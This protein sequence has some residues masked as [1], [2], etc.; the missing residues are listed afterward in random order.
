ME[1]FL[2]IVLLCLTAL[3]FWIRRS[4]PGEFGG[5]LASLRA[6]WEGEED[7]VEKQLF[8]RLAFEAACAAKDK[9]G[10]MRY[11]NAN[12]LIV[13]DY[14]RAYLRDKYPDLRVVDR[15]KH[16]TYAVELALIPT[17]FAVTTARFARDPEV[18]GARSHGYA[19]R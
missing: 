5:T 6:A 1:I 4:R 3:V 14:V 7:V 10:E 2:P 19:V 13:G 17:H 16:A 15:I 18:I 11:T 8:T 12:R 9:F